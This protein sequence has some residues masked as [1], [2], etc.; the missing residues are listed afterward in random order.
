MKGEFF[1]GENVKML[2]KENIYAGIVIF[3]PEIS[4]LKENINH[5][6][7][8]VSKI[9]LYD[10]GS[11]N[12]NSV[13]DLLEKL[14]DSLNTIFLIEG[15]KNMGIAYALN[16]ICEWGIKNKF[17]WC[18]TLDQ[19]SICCDDMIEKMLN[20]ISMPNIGIIA[21]VL[22]H[23]GRDDK[24]SCQNANKNSYQETDGAITSG[25][26]TNLAAWEKINGFDEWLF[27]DGVD[28]DFCTR[29]KLNNYKIIQVLNAEILHSMGNLEHKKFFGKTIT[30]ASHSAFRRYYMARNSIYLHKK[31]GN[32]FKAAFSGIIK[33]FIKVIFFE[34]N[35]LAKLKNIILG[36]IDG[37]KSKPTKNF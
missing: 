3:N 5:I 15:K 33:E 37:L 35:K 23:A 11:S 16:R 13:K 26:L 18:V 29:L 27:I 9:I 36:C 17:S 20:Y 8:Q 28:N 19:D 1:T 10:N 25:A 22:V 2:T 12:V 24:N 31:Y 7:P 6:M 21:P 4:S 30:F 34:T 14:H 32:N